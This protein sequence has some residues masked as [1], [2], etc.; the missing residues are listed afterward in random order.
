MNN[1]A[2]QQLDTPLALYNNPA[3]LF[4]AGFLGS[5]AMNIIDGTLK[6]ERDA[7]VF[8]EAG[9]GT[10][11]ARFE[12]AERPE[13]TAFAGKPVVLGIRPEAIR[14]TERPK[15]KEQ[16]PGSFPA[17][18]DLIEATGAETNLHLD[19]GAHAIVCRSEA[20]LVPGEAGRRMYFQ[21]DLAKAHLFDRATA[22]RII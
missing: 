3:N 22:L 11:E 13:L 4:V 19:T 5:P 10:I 12:S 2:V 16:T 6:Q 8:R 15:P 14:I 9:E 20:S 21:M 17:L 18:V 7:L 1:G